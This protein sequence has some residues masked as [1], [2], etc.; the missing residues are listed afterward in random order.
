MKNL[1]VLAGLLALVAG[2]ASGAVGA[3]PIPSDAQESSQALTQYYDLSIVFTE[4]STAGR[5][6]TDEDA[7]STGV[8]YHG[9]FGIDAAAL[10]TDGYHDVGFES[11]FLS[12]GGY[13]WD[14]LD[15][16]SDYVGSR[17]SNPETGEGGF[18]PWTLLVQNGQLAGICCGVFGASDTPFVDL[19]SFNSPFGQ[20][21]Y[22]NVTAQDFGRPAFSAQGTFSF[23]AV[24]APGSV[25]LVIMGLLFWS[26]R[27]RL[28]PVAR[29]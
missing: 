20:N 28:R 18:G 7:V 24:D 9:T 21:N 12:L 27:T 16:G 10:L 3:M 11:F 4:C 6:C 29:R 5:A 23:K 25:L 14:S 26:L 19:Y 8:A 15:P 13:T 22:V 17:F 2:F 1:K